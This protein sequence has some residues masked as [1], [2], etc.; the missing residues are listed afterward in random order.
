MKIE[1]KR[2][3]ILL[4]PYQGWEKDETEIAY[5]EEVLGL[6]KDGDECICRRINTMNLSRIAYLEI[7]KKKEGRII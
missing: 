7:E 3:K 5:I 1:I 6:K 2:D 4:I